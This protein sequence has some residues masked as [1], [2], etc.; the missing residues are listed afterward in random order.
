[1]VHSS[2]NCCTLYLAHFRVQFNNLNR[3]HFR[4][5]RV[6][7]TSKKLYQSDIVNPIIKSHLYL[8]TKKED[9]YNL[10]YKTQYKCDLMKRD[11]YI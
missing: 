10:K 1:M 2:S 5:Y 6:E 7:Y 11:N 3:L 9:K 8:K 4:R